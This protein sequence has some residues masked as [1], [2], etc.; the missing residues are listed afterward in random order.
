MQRIEWKG[1]VRADE[2]FISNYA[3]DYPGRED[4]AESA[5]AWMAA[6]CRKERQAPNEFLPKVKDIETTIPNRLNYFDKYLSCW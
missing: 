2:N 5:V 1:A 6:R 3:R 4:I